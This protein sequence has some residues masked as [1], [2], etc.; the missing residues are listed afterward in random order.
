[1]FTGEKDQKKL[2]RISWQC[3][4]NGHTSK[5]SLIYLFHKL[6][7]SQLIKEVT[8]TELKKRLI[9]L[10]CNED[11]SSFKTSI[12]SNY[13]QFEADNG[14]HPKIDRLIELLKS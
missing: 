11:G 3:L 7:E 4:Y 12:H 13:K 9:Q 2:K 8:P 10:F 5:K 6:Q 1:V 14:H